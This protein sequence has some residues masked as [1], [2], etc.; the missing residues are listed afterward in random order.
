MLHGFQLFLLPHEQK[1]PLIIIGS[2]IDGGV[3]SPGCLSALGVG[4]SRNHQ[5][6]PYRSCRHAQ[7]SG[8]V[9]NLAILT[10]PSEHQ[11]CYDKMLST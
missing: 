10:A 8:E 7:V 4:T 5:L 11:G 9:K 3:A 2:F 6:Q 1:L